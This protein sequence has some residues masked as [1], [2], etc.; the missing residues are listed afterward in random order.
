[1]PRFS[2]EAQPCPIRPHSHAADDR[3]DNILI[4]INGT[5][6]AR[7][8]ARVSVFDSA[9]MLGD[10]VWEGLR[11]HNGRIAFL[12]RHLERLWHAAKALDFDLGISRAALTERPVRR[13]GRERDE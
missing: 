9:F 7:A 11:V 6:V 10:G 3:N 8:E 1:M 5:L 13:T 2:S 4:D 12:D